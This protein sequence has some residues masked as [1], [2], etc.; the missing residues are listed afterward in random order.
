MGSVEAGMIHNIK[1]QHTI[2]EV[3]FI[4]LFIAF[5]ILTMSC[6]APNDE[7]IITIKKLNNS[8]S[9]SESATKNV[10]KFALLV[11]INQYQYQKNLN[12]AVNDVHNMKSILINRFGFTDDAKH[13]RVLTNEQATRRAILNE[14]QQHLIAN[15]NQQSI[16]VF[17][18]SGH[19]S[20]LKDINGD[21]TDGYDETIVPYD[22]S[23]VAPNPNQDITDDEL[24][25]LLET[26]SNKSPNVTFIFDSC[27]S[28]SAI[29][30]SGLSRTV[31]ADQRVPPKRAYN[32]VIQT[33][34]VNEGKN[35]LRPHDARY[36]L[37]SGAAADE[38]SYELEVD[39]KA[40]G[41][42]SW[43]LA[44]EIRKA[45]ANATYRDIM[46]KVLN[47]VNE[48]YRSQHPQL[49]GPGQD[50]Y[51][52]SDKSLIAEPYI[53]VKPWFKNYVILNV[54]Q[55][56]GIT[57]KSLFDVY[58][59]GTKSFGTNTPTIA[60]IEIN[61]VDTTW[62]KARIVTGEITQAA[63][64]AIE[65]EHHWSDKTLK[66]YIK[67]TKSSETLQKIKSKLSNFKHI[68]FTKIAK[69][70]DLLLR[71]DH[72]NIITEGGDPTEIS[73]R[74]SIKDSNAVTRT[75]KQITH[76]AKWYNIL[77]IDN[78]QSE[79]SINFQLTAINDSNNKKSL[80]LNLPAGQ[81]F[82]MQVSNQSR[83]NIYIAL[84]DLSSDGS[85]SVIL[86]ARGQ[87]EFIAPNQQW[88]TTLKASLPRDKTKMR[89]MLKLI[90][91]TEYADFS[92]LNQGPVTR[93]IALKQSNGKTRNPLEELLANAA[94]GTTRGI[95]QPI[96]KNWKTI[97]RVLNIYRENL[98]TLK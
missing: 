51:I 61:S 95:N 53:L 48:K 67:D 23:H 6:A 37:I 77:A 27:H 43:F 86:P 52:F 54:G 62:S 7:Q 22:S 12:G 50:Q 41:A 1:Q 49:E 57:E 68:K 13:I 9:T 96:I 83:K 8:T 28:G 56:H 92:F 80:N 55:V 17:H 84:L 81:Q 3:L 15:A 93:G 42:M 40:Y 34:T 30:G 25:L 11:G 91:T 82:T 24:N 16:I 59:P 85:V 19:G 94:M 47:R 21:E 98:N 63:S 90:A 65:R 26:L 18:Y 69:G 58:S 70:Y 10:N 20:R 88:K 31:T 72:G 60:K 89:D 14:L 44:D 2:N 5:V 66:I 36:A 39:G 71:Q 29:R 46:E 78:N 87:Q 35:D 76:W 45:K 73:P 4:M 32:T 75:V 33:Q 38:L 74:I 97:N 64:R 79:L